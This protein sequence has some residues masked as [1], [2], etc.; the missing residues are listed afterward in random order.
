MREQFEAGTTVQFTF[1][2]SV[3]PDA[4]P[5]LSLVGSGNTLVHSITAT[6]SSVTM[7]YA[8]V[9]MP[10]SADGLY[11][12]EWFVEKTSAGATHPFY[13]RFVFNVMRTRIR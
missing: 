13:K 4:E 7:Y 8:M 12:G 5:R 3:Q 1:V 10:A 9:T 6:A 11:L 2:S